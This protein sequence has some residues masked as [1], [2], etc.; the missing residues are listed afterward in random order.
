VQRRAVVRLCEP[1][2]NSGTVGDRTPGV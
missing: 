2:A 1:G